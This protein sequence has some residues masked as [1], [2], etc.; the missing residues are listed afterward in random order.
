VSTLLE[1]IEVSLPPAPLFTHIATLWESGSGFGE[2]G[3]VAGVASANRIGPGFRL[4]CSA[5]EWG[6]PADTE[7]EIED[8]DESSGWRARSWPESTLSWTV[9]IAPR[10]TGAELTC[11]LRHAPRG[12]I[13]RV[14]ERLVGRPRRRRSLRSLLRTWKASAERQEALRRLRVVLQ[15]PGPGPPEGA[16]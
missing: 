12:V 10:A 14:K 13:A 5:R 8:Y 9:R 6:L 2:E 16:A 11:L 7:L 15:A 1:R 3:A 4:R